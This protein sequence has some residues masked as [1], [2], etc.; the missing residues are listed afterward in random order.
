[1]PFNCNKCG[2]C[3]RH[4]NNIPQLI[5]FDIGNGV[6]R[7]LKDNICSIYDIRPEIC[8]VDEMYNKYFS[9]QL[10]KEE[11]YVMNEKAC[12]NLQKHGI[13]Y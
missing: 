5:S 7:Y 4:I 1:M 13:S 2:E 8:Q 3:C 12:K 6:C 10:S 11:F 9:E